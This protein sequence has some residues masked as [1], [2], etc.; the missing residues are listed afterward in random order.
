MS[1]HSLDALGTCVVCSGPVAAHDL[2]AAKSLC[3]VCTEWIAHS[4]SRFVSTCSLC[5]A[6][7]RE[8]V[9]EE[10]DVVLCDGC[11]GESIA[12]DEDADEGLAH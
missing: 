3:N 10:R 8:A 5:R 7:L 11:G 6:H 9:I 12:A 4:W 1:V 2:H